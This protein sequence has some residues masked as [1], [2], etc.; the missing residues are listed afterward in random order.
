MRI[1]FGLPIKSLGWTFYRFFL[2]L[3]L[4][5]FVGLLFGRCRWLYPVKMQFSAFSTR[6]DS[7]T[8]FSV[9]CKFFSVIK[10]GDRAFCDRK[11]SMMFERFFF[12]F[13]GVCVSVCLFCMQNQSFRYAS[14][15]QIKSVLHIFCI[16]IFLFCNPV[17]FFVFSY[18]K[19]RLRIFLIKKLI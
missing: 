17:L 11:Q 19:F 9:R 4:F 7:I 3:F 6:V 12:L 8:P 14:L 13:F 18:W 15:H 1:T 5:S 2:F 10:K 16:F